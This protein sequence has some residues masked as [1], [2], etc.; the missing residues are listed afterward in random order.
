MPTS[1]VRSVIRKVDAG[2]ACAVCITVQYCR[3]ERKG[4]YGVRVQVFKYSVLPDDLV[5]PGSSEVQDLIVSRDHQVPLD[6]AIT[7]QLH[8]LIQY[9]G[10][11]H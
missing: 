8:E 4:L 6:A 3:R 10:I 11:E 5:V 1:P 2:S 9:N 7:E